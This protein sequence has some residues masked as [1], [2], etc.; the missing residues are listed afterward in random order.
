MEKKP[1]IIYILGDDHRAE[2]LGCAGHPIVETPNIDRLA[3]EGVYFKNAFC[4]SPVCTPSRCCHYL[5][6]WERRHGVNFNSDSAISEEAFEKSFP[7]ILRKNGYFTGWVG[8]NHVPAG[9][10]GYGGGYFEKSFDYFYGNHGHSGFYP[11]EWSPKVYDNAKLDTQV[12]VFEEGALNFLDPQEDFIRS[13]H[14]PLPKRPKD[15]PF[16]LC[17]TF[18]LPHPCGTGTMQLRPS[19]DELY[20]SKYRDKFGKFPLPKTYIA[21]WSF[22]Q[23]KLP[24]QVYNNVQ[25]SQY[26]FVNTPETLRERMVRIAQTVTGIDRM[27]GHLLEKLEELGEADNTIL[28]FSTDHGIHFGEHGL[29]GKNFL[30]EE[31]LRIPLVIYD[32]RAKKEQQG[33]VREE[34]VLVP[35]LAK[36]MLE[37]MGFPAADT[38]QG[39]S[40]VPLMQGKEVNWRKDFFAEALMD[41]QNYP[42]SE[43]LRTE[44]YKYIRYFKRTEDPAAEGLYRGTLDNYIDC[45]DSTLFDGEE[46]IYEEL[47]DLENDSGETVNLANHPDYETLKNELRLR[48]MESGRDL[49][50]PG[51]PPATYYYKNGK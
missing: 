21:K 14:H 37:L 30:Y 3:R 4:T 11:K 7:V 50:E 17:V 28:V 6:Q 22:K 10:G 9:H 47:Y 26:D 31:D 12:E 16:C 43:C 15:Q 5:G 40:L 18:N 45:L 44:R 20:K 27:I 2:I 42:R 1:N 51:V 8:K 34:M 13:A 48:L 23:P 38:M 36:T 29:G 49:K 39:E 33:Q 35:D 41:I 19:D 46:P 32:P 25:I 24:L